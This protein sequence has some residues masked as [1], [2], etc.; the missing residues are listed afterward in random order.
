M[1]ILGANAKN[2]V[3]CSQ[4]HHDAAVADEHHALEA[5]ALFEIAQHLRYRFGIAFRGVN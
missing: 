2:G 1:R 5:E 3:T 4:A